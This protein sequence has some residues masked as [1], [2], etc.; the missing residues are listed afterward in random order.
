MTKKAKAKKEVFDLF[1]METKTASSEGRVMTFRNPFEAGA[2]ETDLRV[3]CYGPDSKIYKNAKKTLEDKIVAIGAK[4][5]E[6]ET[7]KLTIESL[8]SVIMTWE[9]MV[10]NGVELE[11]TYE[12]FVKALTMVDVFKDQFNNFVGNRENF[13]AGNGK[14]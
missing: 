11:P 14:S 1:S 8:A 6:E 9:N 3:T 7:E 2:P 10:I 13:L 5:T 12:N 4:I